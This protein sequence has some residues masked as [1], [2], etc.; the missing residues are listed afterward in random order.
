M[1]LVFKALILLS[2]LERKAEFGWGSAGTYKVADVRCTKCECHLGWRYLE[3][4]SQSNKYKE[5]CTI[6]E[7]G[8]LAKAL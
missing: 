7:E 8:T 6:L 3:A 1:V 5:G 2:F 4:F